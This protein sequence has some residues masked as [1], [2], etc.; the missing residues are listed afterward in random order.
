MFTVAIRECKQTIDGRHY[1]R[2][3]NVSH[4]HTSIFLMMKLENKLHRVLCSLHQN[5]IST[6]KTYVAVAAQ[7]EYV[8]MGKVS[9]PRMYAVKPRIQKNFQDNYRFYGTLLCICWLYFFIWYPFALL[10]LMVGVFLSFVMHGLGS[11]TINQ[12]IRLDPKYSIPG[13]CAVT[14]IVIMFLA[15]VGRLF[16][17]FCIVSS[18]AGLH[19]LLTTYENPAGIL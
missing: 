8:R 1:W 7:D 14:L 10:A 15:P 12:N 2:S 17:S 4:F 16:W 6:H 19:C 18:F 9:L 11:L 13:V 5:S 3:Q